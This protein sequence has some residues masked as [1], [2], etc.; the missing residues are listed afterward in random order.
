MA[1]SQSLS[2]PE[3]R[4]PH[5]ADSHDPHH[6]VPGSM[7]IS[8]QERTFEGFM[9]VV[10]RTGIAIVVVLVFLALVNA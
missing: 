8:D 6:H 7:D 1:Q 2:H 3:Q 10:V 9:R 5:P 4:T